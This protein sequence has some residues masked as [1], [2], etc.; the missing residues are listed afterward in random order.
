M[1]SYTFV[2]A[3]KPP[4]V[5]IRKLGPKGFVQ[6]VSVQ[7]EQSYIG[8][9]EGATKFDSDSLRSARRSLDSAFNLESAEA[10]IERADEADSSLNLYAYGVWISSIVHSF[11]ALVL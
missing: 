11:D 6:E 7:K 10:H 4:N 2:G 9:Y 3:G 8:L 5:E 1:I